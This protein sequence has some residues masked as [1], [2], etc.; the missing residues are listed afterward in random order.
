MRAAIRPW[1]SREDLFDRSWRTE[2][3][4]AVKRYAWRFSSEILFAL[5][6]VWTHL[7]GMSIAVGK[8]GIHVGC[9]SQRGEL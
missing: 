3:D 5:L 6:D 2:L 9:I 8:E 7:P 1:P 4:D